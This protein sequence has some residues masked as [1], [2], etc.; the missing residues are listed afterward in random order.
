MKV[1]GLEVH[2][3]QIAMCIDAMKAMTNGFRASHIVAA[4]TKSGFEFPMRLADRLL[5][6]E[7]KAG[8]IEVRSGNWWHWIG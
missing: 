2:E 3:A 7:K 5:T 1:Q 8:N 4:A 6:R